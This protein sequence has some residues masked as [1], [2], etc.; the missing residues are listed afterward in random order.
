MRNGLSIS[1]MWKLVSKNSKI[2]LEPRKQ[3]V[4]DNALQYDIKY[5]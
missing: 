2:A 4:H 5:Q 3:E 1:N